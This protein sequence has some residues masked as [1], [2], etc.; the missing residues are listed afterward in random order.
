MELL[1]AQ[2][3]VTAA[4]GSQGKHDGHEQGDGAHG[5]ILPSYELVPQAAQWATPTLRGSAQAEH[6]ATTVRPQ[7]SQ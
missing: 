1:R 4:A 5:A 7:P 6:G 3:V 2:P